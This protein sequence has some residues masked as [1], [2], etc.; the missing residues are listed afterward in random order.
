ME[1]PS[2]F[3]PEAK[4]SREIIREKR[5]NEVHEQ[6]NEVYNVLVSHDGRNYRTYGMDTKNSEIFPFLDGFDIGKLQELYSYP[7][8]L[9]YSNV[10][11]NNPDDKM[12]L[13]NRKAAA[14]AY[15]KVRPDLAKIYTSILSEIRKKEEREI[16][17]KLEKALEGRTVPE[18]A[19][20]KIESR[21]I[22]LGGDLSAEQKMLLQENFPSG[23]FLLHTTDSDKVPLIAEDG[24]LISSIEVE[25]KKQKIWGRGGGEGISF[26]MNDVRVLTGDQRHF[27]GFLAA[28]ENVLSDKTELAIPYSAALHEVRLL[29]KENPNLEPRLGFGMGTLSR[30]VSEL[31]KVSVSQTFIFCNEGDREL[32]RDIFISYGHVPKGIIAYPRSELRMRSWVE[33]VGDHEVAGDLLKDVFEKANLKPSIDWGKD[34]FPFAPFV[35]N[36]TYIRDEDV[37]SSKAIIAID[38]RLRVVERD[39][40]QSKIEEDGQVFDDEQSTSLYSHS[41]LFPRRDVK[42]R[43]RKVF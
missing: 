31:P 2:Q 11:L 29:P 40:I 5:P 6:M 26:N 23:N 10:D 39:P 35:R 19:R 41:P 13:K 7:D 22:V 25:Q 43:I 42:K 32:V 16:R 3:K 18:D 33:P 12:F 37:E 34:L 28:P 17:G 15:A 36:E 27:I 38:G 1:K 30:P 20:E 14:D 21:T 24:F 4:T 9:L 8:G